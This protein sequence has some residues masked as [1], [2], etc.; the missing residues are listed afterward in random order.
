LKPLSAV[1]ATFTESVI[2]EMTRIC[3]EAGGYNLSQ[4]FPDFDPPEEALEAARHAISHGC[5]QYAVTFGQ[6]AFREALAEKLARYNG[7]VCDPATDITVTCGATEAMIA[8]LK[9]LVNPGDEVIVLEP[10]YENYG[11]DAA[12]CGATPRYVSLYP[13]DW[14]F[15]DDELASAFNERT[16]A[17]IVNTPHNPTGKVFSREELMR[18]R[19]LCL[20]WDC[21]CVTD[22]VYEHILFD[23]SI[24]VS[25]A[26]LPD[27]GDRTVTI[28]S[29]SKSYSAT[30]W[31]VGW[32][33]AHRD[34]TARIRKAHD[35]LTVG[36]PAPLQEAGVVALRLPDSYYEGLK[37]RYAEA[38]DFLFRALEDAGF[39]PYLPGG[40]Y[41]LMTETQG[42]MEKLGAQDDHEFARALIRATGVASVP[43]SS[44]YA[45]P[46]KGRRQVRF[47]FAKSLEMLGKA[48]TGLAKLGDLGG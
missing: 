26:A 34:I 17:V 47:C 33:V 12:L 24:H 11:P 14:R 40:A 36:A 46:E 39:K 42:L 2:R 29:M 31:R 37:A 27:M 22:E 30:G 6:P 3:N 28:N 32:T 1:T 13:P 15:D 45:K 48:V 4:G 38:R 21:Y 18:I 5:N 19:D 16:K 35:F 9:A 10:F 7:I 8:A 25:M 43:G 41:Y 23:D 20:E 44:F